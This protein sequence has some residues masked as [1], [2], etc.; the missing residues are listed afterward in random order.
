M[1]NLNNNFKPDYVVHPGK[2]LVETLNEIG[3]SQIELAKRTGIS[4]KTINEIAKYKNGITPETAYKLELVLRIKASFWNNFQKNYEADSERIQRLEIIQKQKDIVKKYT[5]Y[6]RLVELGFVED[7]NNR[8]KDAWEKKLSNL[9]KFFQVASLEYV[10]NNSIA[11]RKSNGEF[12]KENLAAWL[13]SGEILAEKVSVQDFDKDKFI[14]ILPNIKK[15]T[16]K[17]KNFG[18]ELK[19]ICSS[20]GVRIVYTPYFENSKVNGA[21][22]WFKDN[23]LIQ[24]N[25]RGSFSDIFWFTFFHEASHIILH[26][27]KDG[28]I[29]YNDK[30]KDL[31][32]YQ[33]D[34]YAQNILINQKDYNE[35]SSKNK[36]IIKSLLE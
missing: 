29:E 22:R 15:L 1:N 32:E 19:E 28:F 16:S 35:L 33:A 13:R 11:Y 5:C 23:P 12:N 21:V 31:K 17:H 8:L 26:G 36:T 9:L 25:S 10:F 14:N 20:C 30:N 3:M 6:Q 18:K 4:K 34:N 7:V 27:K 24:L 2:V